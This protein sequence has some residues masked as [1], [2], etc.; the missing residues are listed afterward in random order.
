MPV[1]FSSGYKLNLIKKMEKTCYLNPYGPCTE[2]WAFAI[3]FSVWEKAD[4]RLLLKQEDISDP[5]E[6][7]PTNNFLHGPRF[8]SLLFSE[9]EY[10]NCISF[11][12]SKVIRSSFFPKDLSFLC[13]G[14]HHPLLQFTTQW[15]LTFCFTT[16]SHNF[17]S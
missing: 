13:W 14:V 8:L 5:I 9:N 11:K 3:D 4:A 16:L 10:M 7:H 12:A 6:F 15:N 17:R 1:N 2:A